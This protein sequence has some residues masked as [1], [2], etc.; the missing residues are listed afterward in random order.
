ME[1]QDR[2]TQFRIL[3]L[4][5]LLGAAGAFGACGDDGGGSDPVECSPTCSVNGTC[6]DM[7]GT[8]VCQCNAGYMGDGIT[9]EANDAC[10]GI[11][12]CTTTGSTCSGDTLVVCAEN[13]N[14]CLVETPTD[15]T[16]SN[17]ICTLAGG[18]AACAV[19]CD[20]DPI[21][22]GFASGEGFCDAS[23]PVIC[24]DATGCMIPTEG[25]A[26]GAEVCEVNADIPMCVANA[27]GDSCAEVFLVQDNLVLMGTDI[28]AD[29]TDVEAFAGSGCSTTQ[30]SGTPVEAVFMA[31]LSAG[32]TIV[33]SEHTS[34]DSILGILPACDGAGMCYAGADFGEETGIRY[35]AT[36]DET[37][38]LYVSTWSGSPAPTGYEIHFDFSLCGDGVIENGE[39]CDDGNLV[40]DDGCS[41][42]CEQ[43]FGFNCDNS[44]GTTVCSGP[45]GL[46]TYAAAEVIG[47]VVDAIAL[48]EGIFYYYT[49]T[50]SDDVLL[51]GT[52]TAAAAE[53]MTVAVYNDQGVEMFSGDPWENELL[54]AG[55]YTIELEALDDVAATG[56]TMTLSTLAAPVCGNGAFEFGEAC[57]D[58]N[59][60]DMDGCSA[61]C[62]IEV[63]ALCDVGVE[64]SVCTIATDLGT[65]ASTEVIPDEV[66]AGAFAAGELFFYSIT[67]STNA[68]LSGTLDAAGD[69]DIDLRFLDSQGNLIFSEGTGGGEAWTDE[70]L[71]AGTYFIQVTAFAAAPAGWTLTLSTIAGPVCG[72][73]LVEEGEQCDDGDADNLDGCNDVCDIEVGATCD[74]SEPSVC[75]LA[76]DLGTFAAAGAIG[77][78]VSATA[79]AQGDSFFYS[80]T[81]SDNVSFSGTLDA[82]GGEDVDVRILNT[83]GDIIFTRTSAEGVSWSDRGLLAGTYY[84]EVVADDALPT[85]WTLTMSTEAVTDI[86]TF[87][88]AAAIGDTTGGPLVAGNGDVYSITFST[89]VALTGTLVADTGDIDLYVTDVSGPVFTS[90]AI[91][92]ESFSQTLPAGTYLFRAFAYAA[93]D[94]VDVANYTLAMSTAV[95][96]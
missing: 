64:P 5:S 32:E 63:G 79:L 8:G 92:N 19:S 90:F 12:D 52:L 43:D 54:P 96:P 69:E 68:F 46:G 87:A 33:L 34:L 73:S 40:A 6:V 71:D 51:E 11:S 80:I 22:D 56:W 2:M 14:G 59:V 67:F 76:T 57:D 42:T 9:C 55:T 53:G 58:G 16:A 66:N 25:T 13:D 62:V 36:A 30:G 28:T 89:A 95:V 74:A 20:D 45:D 88:A 47:D 1:R 38:F 65:Y 31:N 50:F 93:G 4:V 39:I 3:W 21:C 44:S 82:A 27:T 91:G 83:Q 85:G 35:S 81:F 24:D 18:Q 41:V 10:E 78:A 60:M 61:M 49:I 70:L 75:T 77:D 48:A 86:G 72:N 26:C 15:C 7:A 29:F 84:I 17:E 23:T 94:P 37:V